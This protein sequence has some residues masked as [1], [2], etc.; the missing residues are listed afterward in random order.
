MSEE[1]EPMEFWELWYLFST[2]REIVHRAHLCDE[3]KINNID[4]PWPLLDGPAGG[5][6]GNSP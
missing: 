4:L 5:D 3:L 2:L 6:K 1:L